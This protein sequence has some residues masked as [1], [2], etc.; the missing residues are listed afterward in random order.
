MS[1][2]ASVGKAAIVHSK[3]L[4]DIPFNP[5]TTRLCH[6]GKSYPCLVVGIGLNRKYSATLATYPLPLLPLLRN[7]SH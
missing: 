5:I 1:A 7:G 4:E 3:G 6:G 2:N